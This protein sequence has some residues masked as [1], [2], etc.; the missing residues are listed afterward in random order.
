MYFRIAILTTTAVALAACTSGGEGQVPINVAAVVPPPPVPPTP[1]PP[2]PPTPPPPA[3]ANGLESVD[4]FVVLGIGYRSTAG[5]GPFGDGRHGPLAANPVEAVEFRY[6]PSDGG[7][8]VLLPGF[9]AGRLRLLSYNGSYDASGWQSV[10]GSYH[11]V[12]RGA[13]AELQDVGVNLQRPAGP[14][15][16]D[17]KLRYTSWGN[18]KTQDPVELGDTDVSGFFAYGIPTAAGDVPLS[19]SATYRANVIGETSVLPGQFR[20]IAVSGSA[21]LRFD[22]ASGTLA[23]SMNASVCPWDCVELGR[24]EFRDT[25]YAR[26]ATSFSGKFAVP[27]STGDSFFEGNFTGP[28]AVELLARF[29]APIF[30]PELKEWATMHGIWVGKRD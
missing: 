21:E 9:A 20:Q 15:N 27:N 14:L 30:L 29:Q 17:E 16:P 4:P 26:G 5:G 13:T 28:G 24:Y 1:P 10:T 22:F 7:Y 11:G 12:T 8:E 25:R 2:P 6:L 3:G 23:G 18:W 19:G